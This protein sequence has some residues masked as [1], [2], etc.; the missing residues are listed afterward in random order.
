MVSAGQSAFSHFSIELKDVDREFRATKSEGGK[1]QISDSVQALSRVSL[2]IQQGEFVFLTGQSGAGKSTL[3]KIVLGLDTPTAGEVF[4]LGQAVHKLSESERRALRRQIGIVYQDYKL[5][6][7]LNVRENIEVPL[8]LQNIPVKERNRRV[9]EILET[10]QLQSHANHNVQ[11]LSGGEKQRVALA[12]ALVICPS[13]IIA[14]EP[15]GNLDPQTARSIVRLLR[16][17]KGKGTTVLLA[18]HDMGLVR[19]FG[20]RV[21]ELISGTLP[22]NKNHKAYKVPRFWS[23]AEV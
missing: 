8:T 3:L 13:L 11:T 7:S 10:I 21:L 22:T 20:G 9:D 4:T 16:E 2:R 5:L 1:T 12:R 17:I 6:N 23:G 18:T 14:D 15:T 19:D